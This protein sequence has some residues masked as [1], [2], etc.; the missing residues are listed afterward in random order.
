VP[1]RELVTCGT[2]DEHQDS[3]T[4]KQ[5]KKW[6]KRMTRLGLTFASVVFATLLAAN[7]TASDSDKTTARESASATPYQED[8]TLGKCREECRKKLAECEAGGPMNKQC[9][10]KHTAC[11]NA[12]K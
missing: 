5:L 1:S 2:R 12:C 10:E 6:E 4:V 7:S 3:I 9:R 11:V 8:D